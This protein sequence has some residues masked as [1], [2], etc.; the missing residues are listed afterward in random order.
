M[1]WYMF[2]SNCKM[3]ELWK[4]REK[5]ELRERNIG[6]FCLWKTSSLSPNA[7]LGFHYCTVGCYVST[8]SFCNPRGF[9]VLLSHLC[10]QEGHFLFGPKFSGLGETTSISAPMDG[11][12][13]IL[14]E[15]WMVNPT[16][17]CTTA[18][19]DGTLQFVGWIFWWICHSPLAVGW[20]PLMW[21][22]LVMNLTHQCTSGWNLK[23]LYCLV[24]CNGN[25]WWASINESIMPFLHLE[26]LSTWTQ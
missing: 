15:C 3:L 4:R 2:R 25:N 5:S 23:Y 14:N 10:G 22:I 1:H 6:F 20:K 16:H 9:Q 26:A 18:P 21:I 11:N 12:L 8:Y 7:Q 17:H 19:L 24:L 13:W